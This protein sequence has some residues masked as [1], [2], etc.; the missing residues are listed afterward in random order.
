MEKKVCIFCNYKIKKSPREWTRR[1]TIAFEFS[2]E[3]ICGNCHDGLTEFL[4]SE[5]SPYF[6]YE[7]RRGKMEGGVNG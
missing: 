5:S 2:G 6:P 3:W 4:E 7:P 1:D